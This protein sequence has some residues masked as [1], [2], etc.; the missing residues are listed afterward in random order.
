MTESHPDLRSTKLALAP[1]DVNVQT[2]TDGAILMTSPL[3]LATPPRAVG[4]WLETWANRTPEA[5]FLAERGPGDGATWR[6]LTYGEC[7]QRIRSVAQAL[8]D[9]GLGPNRPV[10]ILSDNSVNQAILTLAGLHAGVPIVPVSPAYALQSTDFEKLKGIVAL[11]S[12]GLVFA[13]NGDAFERALALVDFGSAEITIAT[14]VS[15]QA[16][17]FDTLLDTAATATVD[18]AFAR[19]GPDTVAKILF[20]S[21]STGTPKGVINTQRMLTVNQEQIIALWPFLKSRPPILV[22]WLPWSHTF[23]GNHD[24]NMVL[25]NGGSLYIDA[26]RPTPGQFG[27]T[28]ANLKTVAPTLCFNVPRG[29]DLLVPYLEADAG[30]RDHFFSNLDVMF[31]AGA[32][33]PQT[34]W[35]RLQTLSIA[36]R[37]EPVAI[38]TSWGTTETAPMSTR[39]HYPV[40]RA[41]VIGLPAPSTELKLVPVDGRLEIRVRGPNVTPGYWKRDDLTQQAFD[42]EEYYIAGDAVRL[43]DPDD[44]SHGLLFDG[45]IA[46]DFKLSTG[47]WVQVG[48]LRLDVISATA[49]LVQDCVLTG[50]DSD[51]VALLAFPNLE[52]CRALCPDR[53]ASSPAATVFADQRVRT[54]LQAGLARHNAAKPGSSTRIARALL[55]ADPAAI[56]AGE[57]TDKGYINQRAV[58]AGR[59]HLVTRLHAGPPDDTVIVVD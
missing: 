3:V 4:L 44:P 19:I 27:P 22:D 7:L 8:L 15:D 1:A 37:D 40:E 52:A 57:I 54:A 51:F 53:P 10:M 41:G 13:E 6:R 59:S 9:R 58:L 43:V 46:E 29:F 39:V 49:P 24:F 38:F 18:A 26:G 11:M 33:L 2:R 16:T 35:D 5:L 30:F 14:A 28:L 32:S 34:L 48:Q 45:R 12:P 23:G 25:R 17:A 21:G 36:A 56:D 42:A 20:T 31:Y 47:T 50:H 55:L